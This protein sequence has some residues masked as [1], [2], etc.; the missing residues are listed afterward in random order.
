MS[1]RFFH[2]GT[3]AANAGMSDIPIGTSAQ[4]WLDTDL[5]DLPQMTE[6][7]W[8]QLKIESKSNPDAV[9]DFLKDQQAHYIQQSTSL[10]KIANS[11]VR[12][13]ETLQQQL[14][15]SE[16]SVEDTKKEAVFSRRLAIVA[17]IISIV[18]PVFTDVVA[19][20]LLFG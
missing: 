11:L 7:D 17:V 12:Q 10:E 6:K 18:I 5:P 9:I 16:K 2:F 14:S 3:S 4:A 1:N 20:L 19:P 8:E 13:S 15:Q